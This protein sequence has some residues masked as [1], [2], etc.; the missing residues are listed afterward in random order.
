MRLRSLFAVLVTGLAF[1]PCRGLA[2]TVAK[3]VVRVQAPQTGVPWSALPGLFLA[4]SVLGSGSAVLPTTSVPGIAGP[5]LAAPAPLIAPEVPVIPALAVPGVQASPG[6]SIAA[7]R[8]WSSETKTGRAVEPSALSALWDGT[9]PSEPVDDGIP[10]SAASS[11]PSLLSAPAGRLGSERESGTAETV[12]GSIFDFQPVEKSPDHGLPIFDRVIRWA[13]TRESKDNLKA[14]EFSNAK[15]PGQASVFFYGERH[16][17]RGLIEENM[18]RLVSH[19][20]PGKTA[21]V[22]DEAYFGPTLFGMDALEY[23]SAKGL[24]PGW[25]GERANMPDLRV[26]GWDDRETYQASSR[27]M[28]RHQ[29]AMLDLNQ[30]LFGDQRGLRYYA[31][32]VTRAWEVFRLW[33][34]MRRTALKDRN[35]VLD[36]VVA[37]V[38]AESRLT[39]STVHVIAGAEHLIEKPWWLEAP[40]L[41]TRPRRS[42]VRAVGDTPYWAGM[43]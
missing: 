18:R 41:R 16:T 5:L 15:S 32:V 12:P 20:K 4:P 26:K 3:P 28:R 40:L 24:E 1:A 34:D 27:P 37:E 31:G 13:M 39:G 30:H 22:F 17:D 11:E 10:T 9:L 33:L 19:L 36:N 29:L 23:L 42:L 21:L 25:L 7:L 6:P 38:S 2:G 35:V 14:F 8:D 43:P